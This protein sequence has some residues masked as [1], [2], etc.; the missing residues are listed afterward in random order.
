[1][2]VKKQTEKKMWCLLHC[3]SCLGYVCGNVVT[4]ALVS[5]IRV[6]GPVV[7]HLFLFIHVAA[8]T[9]S[10]V[11]LPFIGIFRLEHFPSP[12]HLRYLND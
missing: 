7:I 12:R 5:W 10:L 3:R 6:V 4:N 9:V 8:Q 1:M 2:Y 11:K